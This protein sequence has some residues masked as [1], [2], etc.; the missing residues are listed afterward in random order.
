MISSLV[1]NRLNLR[2]K[3]VFVGKLAVINA[4]EGSA[5]SYQ[6]GQFVQI[7]QPNEGITKEFIGNY[8]LNLGEHIFVEHLPEQTY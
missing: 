4:L 2:L 3:P 1:K 5:Y 6:D 8:A 7:L